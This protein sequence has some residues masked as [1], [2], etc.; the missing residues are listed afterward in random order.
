MTEIRRL[1]IPDLVE[2]IPTRLSDAR[3]SFSEVYK[4]SALAAEGLSID[5]IQDNQSVSAGTRQDPQA[6]GLGEW[7][8]SRM[9][10]IQEDLI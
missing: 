6:K 7:V 5:W 1:A 10:H 4:R 9:V 2:I 3:G 8:R